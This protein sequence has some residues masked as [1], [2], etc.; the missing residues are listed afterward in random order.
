MS[1]EIDN[2]DNFL[3]KTSLLE[4][5]VKHLRSR[6]IQTRTFQLLHDLVAKTKEPELFSDD[7]LTRT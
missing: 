5:L 2:I 6:P 3:L 1:D 7:D 4:C